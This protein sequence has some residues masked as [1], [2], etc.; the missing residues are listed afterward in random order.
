MM[1][2]QHQRNQMLQT[3]MGMQQ[4]QQIQQQQQQNL[5]YQQQMN[6]IQA[7]RPRPPVN[8]NCTL[9]GNTANCT[10]Y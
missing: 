3:Y 7:N 9:L 8:T 10:S 1:D 5:W 6:A 2:R 4:Q